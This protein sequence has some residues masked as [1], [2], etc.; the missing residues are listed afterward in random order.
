MSENVENLTWF[1]ENCMK[2]GDTS[3]VATSQ[4]A[5][6]T[7][8]PGYR[9]DTYSTAPAVRSVAKSGLI[10]AESNWRYYRVKRLR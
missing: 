7:T 2:V 6:N 5:D 9:F 8:A 4:Y 3:D 1:V 10:S